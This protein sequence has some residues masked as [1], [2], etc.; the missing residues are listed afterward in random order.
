[1]VYTAGHR[2]SRQGRNLTLTVKQGGWNIMIWTEEACQYV[3]KLSNFHITYFPSAKREAVLHTAH[4]EKTLGAEEKTRDVLC[5]TLLPDNQHKSCS[6]S[7]CSSKP[8]HI[9]PVHL[10]KFYIIRIWLF[11]VFPASS[12]FCS[13][14]LHQN[15]F[16]VQVRTGQLLLK[17]KCKKL[18]MCR[19]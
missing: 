9:V 7:Y 13:N 10:I 1:M 19:H 5:A 4:S 12:S 18:W 8:A 11:T 17:T 3:E 16:P 6:S 14:C 2:D 15:H